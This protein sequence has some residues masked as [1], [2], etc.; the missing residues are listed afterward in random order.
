MMQREVMNKLI[1]FIL[2][3]IL[4]N[5]R[6]W[7]S[8]ESQRDSTTQKK[9]AVVFLPVLYYTPETKTAGGALVVKTF[10]AAS[11]EKS[12]RPSTIAPSFIYTQKRQLIGE[13]FADLYLN[14]DVYHFTGTLGYSKFPDKF[15]GVGN[16]T[17]RHLEEDYTPRTAYLNAGFQKKIRPGLHLGLLYTFKHIEILQITAG[18]LL[19]AKNILGSDGGK[20][21]GAGL[22]ASY[23]TRD[24]IYYPA[25]GSYYNFAINWFDGVIGSDYTFTNYNFD[26]RQYFP[27]TASQV[28][29]AQ[30]FLN[31]ISGAPPFQAMSQLGGKTLLRGYYAGRYRDKNLAVVQTEYRSPLWRRFGWVAF[32]GCGEVADQLSRFALH[33]FKTSYGVGL[34]YAVSPKEKINLRLDLGFGKDPFVGPLITI[35]EAF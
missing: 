20:L 27:I 10:H 1:L 33:D 13:I 24:N 9:S 34:R 11:S 30:A 3:P 2:F 31:F 18:G 25:A 17:S 26:G 23:D 4:T 19:A 28:L 5:T 7:A 16:Q 15:Y 32:F 35:G 22:S 21:S 8:A 29:A 6:T 12:G 14:R